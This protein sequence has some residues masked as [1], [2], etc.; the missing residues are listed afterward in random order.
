M[1]YRFDLYIDLRDQG[2][3]NRSYSYAAEAET[4]YLPFVEF[5][6]NLYEKKILNIKVR[7]SAAE[8][9]KE[10][11]KTNLDNV[12]PSRDWVYKMAKSHHYQFKCT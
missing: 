6:R 8:Y 4:V 7:R 1:S 10:F 5:C 11:R 2:K 9:I 12:Y 3:I